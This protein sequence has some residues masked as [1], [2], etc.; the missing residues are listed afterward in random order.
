MDSSE[1]YTCVT[2]AFHG[3]CAPPFATAITDL[4]VELKRV[5]RALH[6]YGEHRHGCPVWSDPQDPS[7]CTCGFTAAF[8]PLER[9]AEGE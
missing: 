2:L 8:Q 6:E 9:I 5:Q 4:A 3:S 7:G 1:F